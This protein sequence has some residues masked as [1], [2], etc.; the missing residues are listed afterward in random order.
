[1]TTNSRRIA[2]V[3]AQPGYRLNIAWQ[4][5]GE[6]VVD[7]TGV[8]HKQGYFAPL[9]DEAT[10]RQVEV[11]DYGTGIEWANGIDYSADS[12][13]MMANEQAAM[14]A[15]GFRAWKREM[16]LSINEM[17][18]I[19]GFSSSTVK[20]YLAGESPIPVAVQIA[21][22]A[23]RENPAILYAR[24]RPRVAGRPRKNPIA[25]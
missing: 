13:E 20:A 15:D 21:C 5:G 25:A 12:L 2:A 19:F 9:K 11:I 23:M 18:D 14:T 17:A 16:E 6:A 7:M 24:F 8:I 4:D 3:E 22:N 1:M 10:F